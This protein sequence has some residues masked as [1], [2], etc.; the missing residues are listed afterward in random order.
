[1]IK[2]ENMNVQKIVSTEE[3]AEKLVSLG[4][5]IVEEK[6]E[7]NDVENFNQEE[8]MNMTMDQLKNICKDNNL[9]GYSKLGKDELINFIINNLRK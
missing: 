7:N 6:T 5:K 1:M 8:L 2:L 4:F 9:E 3:Q